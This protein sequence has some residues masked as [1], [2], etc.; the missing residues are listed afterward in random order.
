MIYLYSIFADN[1]LFY[2]G[3]TKK[4]NV[5]ESY[6]LCFSCSHAIGLDKK[7]YIILQQ[8]AYTCKRKQAISSNISFDSLVKIFKMFEFPIHLLYLFLMF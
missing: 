5:L 1:K 8:V 2:A 7:K 4:I 3:K 6:Y